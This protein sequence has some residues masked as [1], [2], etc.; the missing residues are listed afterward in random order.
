MSVALQEQSEISAAHQAVQLAS[1]TPGEL[2]E[3]E[4]YETLNTEL[5]DRKVE[6]ERLARLLKHPAPSDII[7][8]TGPPDAGKTAVLQ[9]V[10]VRRKSEARATLYINCREKDYMSSQAFA[11]QLKLQLIAQFRS[12]ALKDFALTTLD[13]LSEFRSFVMSLGPTVSPLGVEPGSAFKLFLQHLQ[14]PS[15]TALDDVLKEF[16][17]FLKACKKGPVLPTIII[18]EANQLQQW[19]ETEKNQLDALLRFFVL[20]TKEAKLAHVVLATSEP[21]FEYWLSESTLLVQ[22][23]SWQSLSECVAQL[24]LCTLANVDE[25]VQVMTAINSCFFFRSRTSSF[26]SQSDWRLH[27]TAC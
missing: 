24:M 18:D 27:R 16:I 19:K 11:A 1:L 6:L 5:F 15:I 17:G 8:L 2:L 3:D 4:D 26:H 12:K 25:L 14:S 7:V 20:I 13:S 10:V 22:P 21:F 23:C 9:E